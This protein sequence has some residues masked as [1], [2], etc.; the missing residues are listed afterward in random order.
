MRPGCADQ[1]GREL[2]VMLV[3]LSS[4]GDLPTGAGSAADKAAP[5]S[6]STALL[7]ALLDI[8]LLKFQDRDR[9]V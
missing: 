7:A 8:S 1:K 2:E 6:G 4:K 5:S 3:Q 9:C